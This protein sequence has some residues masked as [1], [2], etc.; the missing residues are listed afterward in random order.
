MHH[1]LARY[2]HIVVDL[3]RCLLPGC[4]PS[5]AGV[6]HAV[7]MLGDISKPPKGSE[8]SVTSASSRRGVKTG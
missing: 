3:G 4:W 8:V 7:I 1:H 6:P 5:G 2:A